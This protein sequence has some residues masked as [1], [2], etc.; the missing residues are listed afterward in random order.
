M[1]STFKAIVVMMI[2][3]M[4]IIGVASVAQA[5]CVTLGADSMSQRICGLP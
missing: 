2:L 1:R 3:A 5:R 4:T